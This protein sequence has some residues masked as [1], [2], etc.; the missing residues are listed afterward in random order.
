MSTDQQNPYGA[1]GELEAPPAARRPLRP[2]VFAVDV[3]L[4]LPLM[5][6]LLLVAPG[7][8]MPH[9]AWELYDWLDLAYPWAPA[10][11]F[12]ALLLLA[13]RNARTLDVRDVASPWVVGWFLVPVV[14]LVLGLKLVL[15]L[16]HRIGCSRRARPLVFVWWAC[17]WSY[18]GMRAYRAWEDSKRA[19]WDDFRPPVLEEIFL[20]FSLAV[21][22]AL[23]TAWVA[24]R[25]ESGLH[26]VTTRPAVDNGGA[27]SISTRQT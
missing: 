19:S 7:R 24:Q 12:L 8:Q 18:A 27:T 17:V 13:H 23:L 25:I 3:L 22:A 1:P 20:Y 4:T 16:W 9:W 26:A 2:L 11:G 15:D 10:V 5:K 21:L 14:N 6:F